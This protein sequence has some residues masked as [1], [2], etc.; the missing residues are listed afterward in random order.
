MFDLIKFVIDALHILDQ[1]IVDLEADLGHAL[2]D[3]SDRATN[4]DG[5]QGADTAPEW[6]GGGL[7]RSGVWQGQ[8]C[9]DVVERAHM[10]QFIMAAV[11]VAIGE[12]VFEPIGAGARQTVDD[13][14][15]H[16]FR[17]IQDAN[18]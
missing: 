17:E 2:D 7:D 15:V 12:I 18:D 5:P 13:E 14:L 3:L 8:P 4:H 1:C 11:P 16:R 9:V 6:C 10:A